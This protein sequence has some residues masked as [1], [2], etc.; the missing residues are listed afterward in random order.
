[1]LLLFWPGPKS[2]SV[3]ELLERGR[4]KVQ[5]LIRFDLDSGPAGIWNDSYA[6]TRD[7]VTYSPA[8]ISIGSIGSQKG[9]SSQQV[10]VTVSGLS[11]SVASIMNGIAWHQRPVLV[12]NAILDEGGRIL[13]VQPRFAGFLDAAP[14]EDA[15]QDT[16]RMTLVIESN[17]RELNRSAGRIRSD[18]D[19]RRVSSTD[20][21]FK[22]TTATA[23]DTRIYW[24]RNGP[25]APGQ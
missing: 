22:H 9:L 14:I 21:F 2:P 3:A 13:G 23:V 16:L 10:E 12:S 17:N 11:P 25:Q 5:T 24:G 7:G 19:Q 4:V 18:A 6:I 20:G 15:D 1:M 8:A